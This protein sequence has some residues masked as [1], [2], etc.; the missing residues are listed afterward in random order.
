[1]FLQRVAEEASWSGFTKVK[2]NYGSILLPIS[3]QCSSRLGK[4]SHSTFDASDKP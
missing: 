1:M 4:D 2:K 3:E